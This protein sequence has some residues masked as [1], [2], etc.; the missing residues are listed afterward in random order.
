MQRHP[1]ILAHMEGP[2]QQHCRCWCGQQAFGHASVTLLLH[3]EHGWHL[4]FG[5]QAAV[6]LANVIEQCGLHRRAS[7]RRAFEHGALL[8]DLHDLRPVEVRRQQWIRLVQ[9]VGYQWPVQAPVPIG[10][11]GQGLER[12][13]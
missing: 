1:Q 6:G 2:R 8:V 11:P 7:R 10:L 12:I 5:Q 4:R 9:G 13:A 3:G